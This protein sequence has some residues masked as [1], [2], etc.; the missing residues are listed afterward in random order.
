MWAKICL[1][2]TGLPSFLT[3]NVNVSC[4]TISSYWRPFKSSIKESIPSLVNV[5]TLFSSSL[6][7]LS[8]NIVFSITLLF[9]LWVLS[10]IGFS[11]IT[12]LL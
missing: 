2:L 12:F 5:I 7:Y 4:F 3:D 11:S 9:I 6:M 10:S 1:S 8:G